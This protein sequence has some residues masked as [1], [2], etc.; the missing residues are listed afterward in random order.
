MKRTSILNKTKQI[1]IFKNLTHNF[2][3]SSIS[4]LKCVLFKEIFIIKG[5]IHS[6]TKN[7]QKERENKEVYKI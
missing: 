5:L 1:E 6:T 4:T 3:N 2:Q 7:I